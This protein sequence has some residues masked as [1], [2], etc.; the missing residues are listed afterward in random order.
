[1]VAAEAQAMAGLRGYVSSDVTPGGKASAKCRSFRQLLNPVASDSTTAS[2]PWP[3][4]G[5]SSVRSGTSR[6]LPALPGLAAG[7]RALKLEDD[8]RR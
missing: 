3:P 6:Q 2:M 7:M 4:V 5:R 8:F 1:M